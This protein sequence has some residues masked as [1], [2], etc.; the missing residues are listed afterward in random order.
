MNFIEVYENLP[1][2]AH[3]RI[4]FYT[5]TPQCM[6]SLGCHFYKVQDIR[7]YSQAENPNI[8]HFGKT[9]F[10]HTKQTLLCKYEGNRRQTSAACPECYCHCQLAC[11]DGLNDRIIPNQ[12]VYKKTKKHLMKYKAVHT[13]LKT[14]ENITKTMFKYHC[15]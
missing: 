13:T 2:E 8:C 5:N 4:M 11:M 1:Q 9:M 3:Q 14:F 15:C 12:P 10:H 6:Y 7:L